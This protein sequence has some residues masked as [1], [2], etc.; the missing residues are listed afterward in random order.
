MTCEQ[1]R[2]KFSELHDGA[3]VGEQADALRTHI[4]A[5]PQCQSEYAAFTRTIAEVRSLD[6]VE[7]PGDLLATIG[8]A[9]DQANPPPTRTRHWAW[10]PA[11]A[12]AACAMVV[13]VG[14]FALQ[15]AGPP[16][17]PAAGPA[18]V[19]SARQEEAPTVVAPDSLPTERS[20]KD[21]DGVPPLTAASATVPSARPPNEASTSGGRSGI[22]AAARTPQRRPGRHGSTPPSGGAPP[23]E[24]ATAEE[25][26]DRSP[27]GPAAPAPPAPSAPAAAAVSN[28]LPEVGRHRSAPGGPPVS[29]G[30]IG[31]LAEVAPPRSMG[32]P[33][34]FAADTQAPKAAEPAPG[35]VEGGPLPH[36]GRLDVRFV[37]PTL[38]Q[39]ATPV[40]SAI[41]VNADTDLPGATV[42]VETRSDLSVLHAQS[43]YVYRGPLTADEPR[44]IEFKLMARKPG[45]QRLR[46]SVETP[47]RGLEAQM[48]A[49]LPGFAPADER[50]PANSLSS[51]ITLH[52]HETPLREAL[53]QIAR[54]GGVPV[55]ID[56]SVGG[57][58]VSYSCV[59]TPAGSVL[60]IL[61]D[62]YGYSIEYRDRA[63]HVSA[64]R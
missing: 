19:V 7:P 1:C 64:R 33:R 20:V 28:P 52:L 58:R 26:L 34:S 27:P 40:T 8:A 29:G 60:R 9:L 2:D 41:W 21:A 22:A 62:T 16:G 56:S 46:I 42:R 5:C 15:T 23:S 35:Q 14:V 44:E 43:G 25:A 32:G 57:E 4:A 12:A 31:P 37:P 50:P 38:R 53:L 49:I 48:E 47:V 45:T 55:I 11:L 54:D 51:P 39:V 17:L 13:F 61:A 30:S 6:A 24:R 18:E 36:T 10:T 59:D 63:Y 3:I